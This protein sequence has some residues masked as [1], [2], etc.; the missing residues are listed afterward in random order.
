MDVA[1]AMGHGHDVHICD[2]IERDRERRGACCTEPDLRLKKMKR[3]DAV[4]NWW[5]LGGK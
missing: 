5:N 3:G 2:G 1:T 4:K